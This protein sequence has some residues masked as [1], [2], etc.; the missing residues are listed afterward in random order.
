[1]AGRG[2]ERLEGFLFT[3]HS[4][5]EGSDKKTKRSKKWSQ[6]LQIFIYD[7]NKDKVAD[8]A[9]DV[10]ANSDARSR[11]PSKIRPWRSGVFW[12]KAS[13]FRQPNAA[14]NQKVQQNDHVEPYVCFVSFEKKDS[15]D[16]IWLPWLEPTQ[17]IQKDGIAKT[18][19]KSSN[20]RFLHAMFHLE[21]DL[22]VYIPIP[23]ESTIVFGSLEVAVN[24]KN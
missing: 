9:L 19:R 5:T 10:L 7:H 3:S 11:T 15:Y 12:K 4:T 24:L 14:T 22:Y 1:M 8:Y 6:D 17:Q 2:G 20:H 18:K 23:I 13:K 16:Y 21:E